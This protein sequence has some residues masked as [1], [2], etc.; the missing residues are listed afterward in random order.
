MAIIEFPILFAPD[1]LKGRPLGGGQIFVGEP[2]LDPQIPINQKTLRIVQEDGT[3]ID[4][5]Q[6]FIVS[7]GGVPTYNGATV[8]LDVDGNYSFKMLDK[9]GVQKYYVENVLSGTPVTNEDLINDLSQ[10]YEFA[11]VAEYKAFATAFPV[12]KVIN[13]LDRGAEFTV[14]SGTGTATG[15][16][17]I[18]SDEV[19]QSI[20]LKVEGTLIATQWGCVGDD[21]FDNTL[22]IESMTTYLESL[23]GQ[24]GGIIQ[25][26]EGVFRYSRI[27]VKSEIIHQGVGMAATA[28]L[29]NDSTTLD[30]NSTIG[31]SFFKPDDGNRVFRAGWKNMYIGSAL[32]GVA[33]SEDI[34]QN[35][36]GIM[37][38][39]CERSILENVQ[40][41]GFGQGAI[42]LARCQAGDEGLGFDNT[43]QDGNYNT[44][45][46]IHISAC[47]KYQASNSAIWFK[48]KANSNKFFAV[49]A[50]GLTAKTFAFSFAN[51]NAVY[52]C[53][54]E[55]AVS[56]ASFG[57]NGWGNSIFGSRA[58][59]LTGDAFLFDGDSQDNLVCGTYLT[60]VTGEDF[61]GLLTSK[62]NTA[63]GNRV[64]TLVKQVFPPATS[65]STTHQLGQIETTSIVGFAADPLVVK[66]REYNDG[67]YPVM[68]F[69]NSTIPAVANDILFDIQGFNNDSSG[70]AAGVS[71]S[72]KG[73]FENASGLSAIELYAGTGTTLAPCARASLSTTAGETRFMIYDVDNGTMERVIV[74]A[75][76]S[77]GAGFKVLRIPN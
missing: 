57:G 21:S 39:G 53:T 8:R 52:G 25:Y 69:W 62:G 37:L 5:G 47:G 64:A 28:L 27:R 16:K 45:E 14:I 31:S 40:F 22:I 11:T 59:G 10:A 58:E 63:I 7:F 76:D 4:V 48:Y 56:I 34:F 54:A 1:P 35:V 60:G 2:D 18:A 29:T 24:G 15:Y 49:Y 3:K 65:V 50:K 61:A 44:G 70:G 71:C 12:G 73:V 51:D 13:L 77:G 32:S 67:T 36:C 9:L 23:A 42:I 46:S 17:I 33:A 41:G 75:A 19:S 30:S 20:D 74:G 55:S 6:P 26:G 66:A 72:V 68:Q 43:T 38:A